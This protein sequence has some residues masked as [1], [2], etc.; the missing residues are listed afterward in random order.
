MGYQ[1]RYVTHLAAG[2]DLVFAIEM[3]LRQR[4]AE[5]LAPLL[6]VPAEEILHHRIGVMLDRT[7]RQ[8]AQ[9]P[10]Q[11]LEL[12][13]GARVD[14]PMTGIVRAGRQFI[15]KHVAI[16]GHKHFDREHPDQVEL[17]RDV[18]GDDFSLADS[19]LT[20]LGEPHNPCRR[21]A[22]LGFE[23]DYVDI[24]GLNAWLAKRLRGLT[25]RADS[26]RAGRPRRAKAHDA[27]APR[28]CF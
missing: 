15:D 26:D 20:G 22:G 13:G 10:H 21:I 18:A 14:R 3:Q 5:R 9:C 4:V 16:L 8:T 24:D 2:L 12:A 11:L 19:V 6:D 27:S 28:R 7:E 23:K 1:P 25:G 17:G